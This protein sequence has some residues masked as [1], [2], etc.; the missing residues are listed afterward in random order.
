L[1]SNA[2][3]ICLFLLLITQEKPFFLFWH[4]Y[5]DVANNIN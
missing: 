4:G 2:T 3:L 1:W 5:A